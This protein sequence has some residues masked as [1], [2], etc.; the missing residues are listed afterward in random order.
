MIKILVGVP[1]SGKSTWKLQFLAKNPEWVA[2][3]RDDFRYMLK[4]AGWCTPDIE[5]AITDMVDFSIKRLL[6]AKKKVVYDATNCNLK[7]LNEFI[8]KYQPLSDIEFQIFDIPLQVAIERDSQ[9]ERKVGEDVI[10]NMHKD[11]LGLYDCNFDFSMRKQ[12]RHKAKYVKPVFDKNLP[13]CVLCDLDGTLFHINGRSPF[14]PNGVENDDL[15]I[16]ISQLL[17]GHTQLGHKV[18]FMSG[19]EELAR[20]GTIKALTTHGIQFDGLHM[21]ATGD[22]RKDSIIKKELY[23]MNI[24]DKYNVLCVYDDRD[25]VVKLWRDLGL[26]CLQ[27][28]YGDF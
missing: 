11:Y 21:R 13:N 18:I 19:R 26:K 17:K 9:R 6:R 15:D 4:N 1:A 5:N 24:M 12:I 22:S 16:V 23:E 10:K 20:A 3:G 7:R 2:I 14:D 28:E 25:Q 27:V 8:Q